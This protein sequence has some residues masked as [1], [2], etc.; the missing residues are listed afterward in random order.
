[1]NIVLG[2]TVLTTRG[3]KNQ[4]AVA[5]GLILVAFLVFLGYLFPGLSSW[6]ATKTFF[7]LV[8]CLVF[9]ILILGFFII[10]QIVAPVVKITSEARGIAEGDL[11]RQIHLFRED[12]IGQLGAALN[13]MTKRMKENVEDLK[14]FTRTTETLNAEINRQVMILSNLLE[15]SNLI[16]QNAQLKEIIEIG[17]GKCLSSGVM[18][19]GALILKDDQ[20]GEY[21][22]HY[23]SGQNSE[24]LSRQ[25]IKDLKISLG[26]GV[27]G[28]G[29]LKQKIVVIDENA[30]APVETKK[31]RSQFL[32]RNAILVPITAKGNLYGLLVAGNDEKNFIFSNAEREFLQLIAKQLAIALGSELLKK[33]IERLE[34]IDRLTGLFNGAY[35]HNRLPEEIK[36]AV[37]FQRPCSFMLVMIDHFEDYRK[38]FGH[39]AAEEIL[40]KMGSILK[41]IVS[42][43]DKAARFGDH[44]FALILP[45]KNKRQSIEI[46]E[47]IRKKIEQIFSQEKNSRK[48]LTCSLAVTE[49][50]VDGL[51]AQDL[52]TK[53]E[54]VLKATVQQG[55]NKVGY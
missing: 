7:H 51:S 25:G 31:F 14:N 46:G 4:L 19:L 11:D 28:K 3:I 35:V 52:I 42:V 50:P 10:V 2:K 5:L 12:E 55:G 43:V 9:L 45:E 18:T 21:Q 24:E 1:L 34:A 6:F 48:K 26:S 33:E 22:V 17:V 27:L 44:T 49:N 13:R 29:L 20:T 53:A 32:I 40:V 54:D 36:R 38:A 47:E 8:V 15:I 41:E 39:M 23:V 16:A 30:L 37:N